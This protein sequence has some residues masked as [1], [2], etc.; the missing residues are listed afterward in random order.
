MQWFWVLRST[1]KKNMVIT[2]LF[3]LSVLVASCYMP[4]IFRAWNRVTFIL[5]KQMFN[6]D[7]NDVWLLIL[8]RIFLQLL[9]KPVQIN[10]FLLKS[11]LMLEKKTSNRENQSDPEVGYMDAM[12]K[13]K[14]HTLTFHI[15]MVNDPLKDEI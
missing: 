7:S 6:I 14:T 15:R 1:A 11:L 12:T 8:L 3:F 2:L 9:W 13:K 5:N 4:N 10:T